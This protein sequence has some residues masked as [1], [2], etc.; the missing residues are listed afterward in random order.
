MYQLLPQPNASLGGQ[1][2]LQL[3]RMPLDSSAS[4]EELMMQLTKQVRAEIQSQHVA[5]T[6]CSNGHFCSLILQCIVRCTR[7]GRWL[8]AG[9]EAAHVFS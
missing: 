3:L 7:R 6:A 8:E 9:Q 4:V 5:P 1:F 2:K